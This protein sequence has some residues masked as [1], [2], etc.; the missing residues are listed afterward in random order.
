M[1]AMDIKLIEF[2]PYS[3]DLALAHFFLFPKVKKVLASLT[4]TQDTFKKER[5][6]AA[7]SITAADF[8]ET[9]QRWSQCQE[10]C[11]VMGGRY[12]EKS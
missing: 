9:F 7:R 6:G 10:N 2:P 1:A 4:L 11:V 5:E 3:P 8:A 12:V